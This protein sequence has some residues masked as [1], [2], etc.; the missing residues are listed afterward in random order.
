[1]RW[2][3]AGIVIAFGFL[4]FDQKQV[5]AWLASQP[6]GSA[7]LGGAPGNV[8]TSIM[9]AG[10]GGAAAAT[11]GAS[12]GCGVAATA[13]IVANGVTAPGNAP[14][15]GSIAAP[16]VAPYSDPNAEQFYW[17]TLEGN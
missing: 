9:T 1:M 10:G 4:Y 2:F 17:D 16:S 15:S 5:A 11:A 7:S 6:G 12:C 14:R 8:T 3:I 13:P